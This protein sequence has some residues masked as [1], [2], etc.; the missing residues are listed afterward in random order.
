MSAYVREAMPGDTWLVLPTVRE[1]DVTELAALDTTPEQCMRGGMAA[2]RRSWVMFIEG[3]PAALF[4]HVEHDGYAVPWAVVTTQAERHPLPFLRISR[5]FI[6]SLPMMLVNM[7]DAR[8][9][10]VIRWLE[11]LGFTIEEPVPYGKNGELFRRF[12]RCAIQHS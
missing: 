11:W 2:S 7:V 3:E 5:A 9:E 4:G 6:R 12:T 10:Q 8:N 1:S